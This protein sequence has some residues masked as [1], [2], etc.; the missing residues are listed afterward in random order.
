MKSE[1]RMAQNTLIPVNDIPIMVPISK[2]NRGESD[3]HFIL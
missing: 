1:D 2:V 3:P